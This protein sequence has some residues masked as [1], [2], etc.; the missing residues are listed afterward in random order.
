[1]EHLEKKTFPLIFSFQLL[2]ITSQGKFKSPLIPEVRSRYLLS[3]QLQGFLILSGQ[4]VLLLLGSK[5]FQIMNEQK[6]C[7]TLGST[8]DVCVSLS[9]L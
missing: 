3:Y 2:F 9:Q 7:G 1:M 8:V 5:K 4:L 6:T